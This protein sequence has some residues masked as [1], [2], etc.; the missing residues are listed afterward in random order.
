M[1]KII[2]LSLLT[3]GLMAILMLDP[4]LR[5]SAPTEIYAA[6]LLNPATKPEAELIQATALYTLYDG[7]LGNLPEDQGFFIYLTFNFPGPPAATQTATSNGVIL[8]SMT[9]T[10]DYAGYVR[11]PNEMPTILDRTSGYTVSFTVQITSEAHTNSDRAGFSLTVLSSD[12]DGIELGFWTNEIWAQDDDSND[13]N[14]LLTHAEGV[15][16]TTTS[17]TPYSLAIFSN[18]Y[19]LSTNGNP[20]LSGTLRNYS[21]FNPPLGAPNPYTST[22]FISLGD[23][24]SSARARIK[25]AAVSI[26]TAP[27][28]TYLPMILKNS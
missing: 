5:H 10:T 3:L 1:L 21:A 22:N 11:D 16:F 19:T 24:T 6:A 17:L 14:D 12:S 4:L 8:D 23:N 28:T 20:I 9:A 7:S 26:S 15:T 13:P 25:L 18:T 2:R 27:T